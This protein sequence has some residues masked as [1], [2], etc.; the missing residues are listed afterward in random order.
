MFEEINGILYL[1][2]IK[3][4]SDESTIPKILEKLRKVFLPLKESEDFPKINDNKYLMIFIVV[5]KK[6]DIYYEVFDFNRARDNFDKHCE[7]FFV[8]SDV[9][10]Q[11]QIL[12]ISEI[13]K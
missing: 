9:N 12:K 2:L 4:N 10:F 13:K 1:S 7:D 11:P 5:L 8:Q 3:I 6:Q